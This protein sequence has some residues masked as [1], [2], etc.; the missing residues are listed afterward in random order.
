MCMPDVYGDTVVSLCVLIYYHDFLGFLVTS[1][2]CE[3]YHHYRHHQYDYS[4]SVSPFEGG[5][6]LSMER[7]KRRTFYL[8][9][10]SLNCWKAKTLQI[11]F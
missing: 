11:W 8:L 10:V 1:F 4:T 3:C 5:I 6:F 7:K 2:L 9:H